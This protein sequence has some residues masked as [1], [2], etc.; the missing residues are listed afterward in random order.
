MIY[1]IGTDIV[2]V[3]RI[4]QALKR[5]GDRFARRILAVVEWD[6]FAASVHRARFL[7]KRFAAK[8]AFVKALGTGMRHPATWHNINVTHDALGR[9]GFG[10]SPDLTQGL[11]QR[12]IRKHHLSISDEA[13]M[14]VAF[15]ILEQ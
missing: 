15:S 4:E 11:A 12:G 2:A 7:A 13:E 6:D 8:E 14:V 5:H 3:G 1:G 10:F 9:P